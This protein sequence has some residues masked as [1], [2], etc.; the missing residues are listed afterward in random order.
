M[1]FRDEG[2]PKPHRSG[3][4]PERTIYP[5]LLWGLALTVAGAVRCLDISHTPMAKKF[6]C[7]VPIMDEGES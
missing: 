7:L 4:H 5:N 2:H 1:S 3:T 6:C